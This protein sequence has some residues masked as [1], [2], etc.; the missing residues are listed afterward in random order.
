[1]GKYQQQP[2]ERS[3]RQLRIGQEIRR[4][5]SAV[6]LRDT[7]IDAAHVDVSLTVSE[8]QISPDMKH[9]T[10]FVMS[11]GGS[12]G[13]EI[14]DLLKENIPQYRSAIAK[15]VR[16]KFVPNLIFKIDETFDEAERI[17]N[18]LNQPRVKQD[19]A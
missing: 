12:L 16:M 13:D 18:L 7:M 5:L 15:Q 6:M 4:V 19:L 17:A 3:Q 2:R 14:I 8:V 1:M 11:L 9:A 10:V